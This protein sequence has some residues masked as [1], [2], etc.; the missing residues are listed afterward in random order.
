MGNGTYR[1][2]L[3]EACNIAGNETALAKRLHKPKPKVVCWLLGS[4]SVPDDVFLQA[5]DIV[6]A[7]KK[8]HIEDADLFVRQI[9][10]RN[11]L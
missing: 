9:R 11:H 1:R 3:M 4:A 2:T 5:V 10:R 6:T 7:S 8:R